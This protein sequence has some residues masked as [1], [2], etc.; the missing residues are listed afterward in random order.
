VLLSFII[1]ASI[2]IILSAIIIVQEIRGREAKIVRKLLLSLGDQQIIT[3]I[4]IQC[5]G[6][7]KME[8]LDPYH[9]FIVWMLSLLSTSTHLSTLLALVNDFKRDWMLRWLRQILMLVNLVLSSVSGIFVL[10]SVLKN[11]KPT[12]PIACAWVLPS[13]PAASN[14]A[15]S[16]V[17]TVAVTAGNCI[18]FGL[19]VWFLHIEN[20]K[21]IKYIQSLGYCVLVAGAV[22]ATVRVLQISQAFGH[23]S[24][25]LADTQEEDWSF[26]QILPILLLLLPLLSAVELIRGTPIL[27]YHDITDASQER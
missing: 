2:A 21:W 6:L 20:R 15:V 18:V 1:T 22:G 4:A 17:G 9:F 16:V 7:A 25:T 12:L 8:F 11:L 5:V 19:A 24:V 13:G 14:A 3:G 27:L 23:P 26:G 10:K